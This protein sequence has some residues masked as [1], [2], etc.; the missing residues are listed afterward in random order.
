MLL[1][2]LKINI[3]GLR[4][5]EE[6]IV[7][8]YKMLFLLQIYFHSQIHNINLFFIT[9]RCDG[10]SNIGWLFGVMLV[11]LVVVVEEF[12]FKYVDRYAKSH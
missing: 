7:K 11:L 10:Y 4:T 6:M 8:K 9:P 1:S 3:G 2:Y 5:T 12:S